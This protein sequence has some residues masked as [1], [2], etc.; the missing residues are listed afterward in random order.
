M[1]DVRAALQD[2]FRVMGDDDRGDPVL[3]LPQQSTEAL[4]A[5]PVETGSGLVV[6]EDFL[7]GTEGR[8][9]GHS[10]LLSAGQRGGKPAR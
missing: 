3:H 2:E 10:L 8:S 7:S 4:H 6:K 1:E 5:A 9:D